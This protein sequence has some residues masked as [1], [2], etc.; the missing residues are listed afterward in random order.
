MARTTLSTTVFFVASLLMLVV[1][2]PQKSDLRA[3]AATSTPHFIWWEGETPN[4][5]NF[6]ERSDFSKETFDE[7]ALVLLSAGDWLSSS[8]NRTTDT[9]LVA[10]YDVKV[11]VELGRKSTW[12][13]W[14]RKFWK[15]GPFRWRFGEER[16][17][18]CDQRCGLEDNTPLR[19]FV[20]ACWVHLGAVELAKGTHRLEVELL[21][22]K[23]Q[24]AT[25]CFD[26]FCLI[27]GD[28][29][30]RGKLKP[31]EHAP[32]TDSA[33][34]WDLQPGVNPH[35]SNIGASPI[36]MRAILGKG[37]RA[38]DGFARKDERLKDA[39]DRSVRLWGVNIGPGVLELGEPSLRYLAQRLAFNGVNY[40]RLHGAVYDAAKTGSVDEFRLERLQL[41]ASMLKEQGIC[42]GIS[43]YFPLWVQVSKDAW[44]IE[45]YEETRNKHPFSLI[46]FDESLQKKHQSWL[47][48]V[49]LASN[50]YGKPFAQ[51]PACAMVELVNEDSFLF[52]TFS[53]DNIPVPLLDTLEKAFATWLR[54]EHGSVD[55]ALK[56]WGWQ[57][58]PRDDAKRGRIQLLNAWDMTRQGATQSEA[59]R[60]RMSDQLRF[61]VETQ[62]T[63]Y[64]D[65]T[66]FLRRKC[67]YKGL[68]TCGNWHT[69]D[70]ATLGA[71]EH[72]TYT[73]GDIIDSHAYFGGAHS[74]DGASYSVRPGQKFKDRSALKDLTSSPIALSQL[75]G[76]PRMVSE[77]GWPNPN[78]YRAEMAPLLAAYGALHG[79]DCWATFA[80]TTAHWDASPEKFA[81][82]DP[83]MIGQF[84]AW[85]LAFRR[86]DIQEADVITLEKL[87]L[88]DL[89]AFK[90]SA[91][92]APQSLDA[93]READI[94]KNRGGDSGRAE[95]LDPRT[96]LIGKCVQSVGTSSGKAEVTDISANLPR[97]GESVVSAT[98]ELTWMRNPGVLLVDTPRCQAAVG[99]LGA[100]GR[101]GAAGMSYATKDLE[102]FCDNEYASLVAISLDGEPLRSSQRIL[103][104]VGTESRHRGW[105]AENDTIASTGNFPFEVR[106]LS[107]ILTLRRGRDITKVKVLDPWGS[108]TEARPITD[109]DRDGEA[110]T[111][112]LPKR[113]LYMLLEGDDA[114]KE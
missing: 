67:R 72:Y 76:Y 14:T 89:Y 83:L 1:L 26:C 84:P 46:F 100:S 11:D 75:E 49:L 65:S 37:V 42:Y 6:P 40:V 22:E 50:P 23:G 39:K 20:T 24:S 19:P 95:S 93:L 51:D 81:L 64:E 63:Y 108:V 21:A 35:L 58:Q 43:L 3:Q 10:R 113:S 48:G 70:A 5:T 52:W 45:G 15:H 7:G 32:A 28:F 79:V 99:F 110:L 78:R 8:G 47:S 92:S 87:K 36:D 112:A 104:Q 91:I 68:V 34:W 97:N 31:G 59:K 12:Q 16:W 82:C 77:I 74:G 4:E 57:E 29:E 44:G 60:K 98:G 27:A 105:K 54:K 2:P 96:F 103:V 80:I 114:G 73:P 41:F 62:R 88:D 66:N 38:S 69:A 106:E 55:K 102:W 17:Q 25:A 111:I 107:G 86:G 33:G 94:P 18:T 71:L 85:S 9:P 90:G 61:L 109:A 53:S 30:P 56:A 13:L 101:G